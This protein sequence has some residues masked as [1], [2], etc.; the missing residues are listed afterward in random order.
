MN[1]PTRSFTDIIRDMSAAIT[2]SAGGLIDVSV[3]S[4]LRAILEANGAIV[5][6]VQWLVLLT[7][8]TT[9]AA[10]S[11][12]GD[13]D[14]WMADFS[15]IR[16]AAA[17]ASGVAT[18][19]R[20]SGTTTVYVPAGTAMKTQDGSVTFAVVADPTNPAWQSFLNSYSLAIGVMSIDLPIT[21]SVAGSEGNVLANTISVLA[22]AVPG[23]DFVNNAAPTEGGEDPE[24]DIAFRTRFANFF[25][26]RSRAT[27]DAIG[28]AICLS[29]QNLDYVIQENVDA[30]GN[31][32][33]GNMLIV[34]NDGTGGLSDSLLNSISLSVDAVRAIGTTFSIQPPQIIQVQV[35]LSV[36][37]PPEPLTS[38]VQAELQSA[39][40]AYISERT[41]G[42][43]LSIT[44]ISQLI[45]QT[46]PQVIN[47]S[48]V[49]LNN[50]A[51]DLVA[52]ITSVFTCQSIGFI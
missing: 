43:T 47:V 28:Y 16:L 26:S 41:I 46:E 4:V 30:S 17:T 6:W 34:V 44:R 20:Y 10:T 38:T 12:G 33:P 11:S 27:A 22:S 51:L 37:L 49:M 18:F 7:L 3:G 9:R 52:P 23:I 36:D 1:L 35:S 40:E 31:T 24:S 25:A 48:N 15:F 2:A 50:Q 8:Q 13:L 42:S 45:Y 39:I 21:A 29:G 19:S 5:L 32:S 14:S